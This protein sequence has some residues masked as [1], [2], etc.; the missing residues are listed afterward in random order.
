MIDMNRPDAHDPT[1]FSTQASILN[2][3]RLAARLRAGI[4]IS[5]ENLRARGVI[6][7]LAIIFIGEDPAS[8]AYIKRKHADC[9]ETGIES[10]D[11]RLVART[12][13]EQLLAKINELNADFSIHGIMVQLPLPPHMN[14]AEI[15][16][17]IDPAKDVDGLHPQNLGCLLVGK[18]RIM[19]CTPRGILALLREYD[20]PISGRRVAILGR[21][22]LVGRP[23]A[24]LLSMQGIDASVTLLHSLS[25]DIDTETRRADIVISAIGK[26]GFVTGKMVQS[27]AAVLGV[28]IS[29]NALGEMLS[30]IAPDVV[31]VAKWLTP[32]PGS[33]GA[34]TRTYLLENLLSI[35]SRQSVRSECP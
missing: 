2:G 23:L 25:A 5:C 13:S 15:L 26:P 29:Y 18:P 9:V 31:T 11:I 35:A 12:S 17:A 1:V 4:R 16:T 33:V 28:G 32:G 34:L 8:A 30:D 7:R 27:G 10:L 3:E 22:A 6:P 24:M 19:P 21:G 20:I 14:E